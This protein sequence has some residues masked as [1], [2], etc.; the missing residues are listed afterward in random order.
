M[1]NIIQIVKEYIEEEK[2]IY[3]IAEKHGTYAQKIRRL[4][5]KNGVSLRSKGDAQSI[6]LSSG[7]MKHPTKGVGH[8]E[9]AKAK[10]SESAH[11]TW[12]KMDDSTYETR[13]NKVS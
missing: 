1:L 7:R 2:S 4:L 11:S 10:I 5:I 3:E 9:E 6:A 12:E 8:S 13:V